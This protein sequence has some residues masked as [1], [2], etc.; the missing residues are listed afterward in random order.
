M[1]SELSS[2]PLPSQGI[3][4]EF[5]NLE[6]NTVFFN[7]RGIYSL[8]L[9]FFQEFVLLKTELMKILSVDVLL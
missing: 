2:S 8:Q 1:L 9:V 3:V 5:Q 4:R 6:N 7:N